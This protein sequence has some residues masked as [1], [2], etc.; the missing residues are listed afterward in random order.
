MSKGRSIT[1]FPFPPNRGIRELVSLLV[2]HGDGVDTWRWILRL[3]CILGCRWRQRL[4][5][6]R[7]QNNLGDKDRDREN[8]PSRGSHHARKGCLDP[9]CL[10]G[11]TLA[12]DSCRSMCQAAKECTRTHVSCQG[13]WDECLY[14]CLALPPRLCVYAFMC[15]HVSARAG[16]LEERSSSGKERTESRRRG[17]GVRMQE[18][19]TVLLL[20]VLL[21][22]LLSFAI[23][24]LLR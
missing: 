5:R 4:W 1:C 13:M 16:V 9:R 8:D 2:S 15:V 19:G 20:A 17:R 10:S 6:T 22:D 21:P 18:S 14:V 24:L 3:D 23:W 7:L 12:P 11:W